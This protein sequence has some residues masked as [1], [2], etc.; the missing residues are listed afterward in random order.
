MRK[1]RYLL[2]KIFLSIY[3]HVELFEF[4]FSTVDIIGFIKNY[5]QF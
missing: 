4:I 3:V 2:L 5:K 1:M